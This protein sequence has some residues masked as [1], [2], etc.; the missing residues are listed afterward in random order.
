MTEGRFKRSK[1]VAIFTR[2]ITPYSSPS[3]QSEI[4]SL[5]RLHALSLDQ[6]GKVHSTG[7]GTGRGPGAWIRQDSRGLRLVELVKMSMPDWS[8]PALQPLLA[9]HASSALVV[10][11]L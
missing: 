6:L 2:L 11:F 1:A 7:T 9:A 5:E 3:E 8:C 4:K 10:H